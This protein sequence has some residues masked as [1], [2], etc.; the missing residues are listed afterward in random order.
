MK[1]LQKSNQTM[2]NKNSLDRA[3][4]DSLSSENRKLETENQQLKDEK[5]KIR[6][7]NMN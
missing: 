5:R 7:H 6:M 4:I 2:T 3:T 1:E